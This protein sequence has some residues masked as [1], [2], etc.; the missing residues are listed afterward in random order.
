L[1]YIEKIHLDLD[2]TAVARSWLARAIAVA[3]IEQ[4][5]GISCLFRKLNPA[6]LASKSL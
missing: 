1:H 6:S 5:S 4:S 3:A 2:Q